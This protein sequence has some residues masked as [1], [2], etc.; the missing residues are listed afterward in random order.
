MTREDA[1]II[2]SN[3]SELAIFS[4]TFG[5]RLEEALGSVLTGG[6][7]EDHVG[8]LFLELVRP[9]LQY[10]TYD[11]AEPVLRRYQP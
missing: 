6:V 7:G 2:F 5:D 11:F 10:L 1:R 8:A 9:Y 4:D 3:I